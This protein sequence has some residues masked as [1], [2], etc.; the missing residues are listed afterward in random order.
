M[1]HLLS[2]IQFMTVIP[3]GRSDV[4]DPKAM[5]PYFPVVGLLLGGLTAAFD[6]IV[7]RIWPAPVASLLDVVFLVLLTGAFHLDGLGDTADGLFGHRPR[8]RV[9]EIMKDSRVGV[10]GLTAIICGLSLKFAGIMGLTSD[11]S[12]LLVIVPAYARAGM[13]FGIRYLAY[14]RSEEGIGYGFFGAPLKLSAFAGCLLPVLLSL[15]LGKKAIWLNVCFLALAAAILGYYQKRL[16]CITGDMMGALTEGL[17]SLL[18]LLL[19][20][21]ELR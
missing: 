9:L 7:L 18:F 3:V 13:V 4:F 16:G 11:R 5:V 2:A 8:E 21:G 19:S 6:Q 12:L 17:E 20:I 1:K 15:F 10:M 14:G